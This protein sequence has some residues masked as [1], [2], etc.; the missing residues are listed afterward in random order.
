MIEKPDK[1]TGEEFRQHVADVIDYLDKYLCYFRDACP[2]SRKSFSDG[3]TT[4]F[5]LFNHVIY[6]KDE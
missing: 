1:M 5:S 6:E 3:M 4:M 2:P